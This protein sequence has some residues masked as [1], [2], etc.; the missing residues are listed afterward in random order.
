MYIL[1]FQINSFNTFSL[2]KKEKT[3]FQT[4]IAS[5]ESDYD[6]IKV[7]YSIEFHLYTLFLF[8]REN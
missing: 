7:S 5:L 1:L 6:E 4:K 2:K 3:K 8:P